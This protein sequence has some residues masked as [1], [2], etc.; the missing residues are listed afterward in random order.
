MKNGVLVVAQWVKDTPVVSV[1]MWVQPLA[2]LSGL[3]IQRGCGYS[4]KPQLQLRFDPKLGN[5]HKAGAAI[6]RT[7]YN[8]IF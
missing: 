5:F 4:I 6:K 1:T 7:K 2:S 8:K 3:R